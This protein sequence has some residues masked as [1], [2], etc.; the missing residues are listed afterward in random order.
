[1]KICK[2]ILVALIVL[3]TLS[4]TA[5]AY[6]GDISIT[7]NPL[8]LSTENLLEGKTVRIYA[9]VTNTSTQDLLGVT[10]FYANGKQI[11]ADQAISIFA[12]KTDD[13]F[14][15]WIPGYGNYTLKV[16]IFPW[17]AEIDDP[18]NNIKTK[19]IF[20][21]KDT[22]RD[23]TPDINDPDDDNDGLAD[24]I[25]A[26]PTDKN[27]QYD[28]DGDGKGDNSDT[29][30]DNDGVP[31]QFDDLPLDPN[32]S[33]DTDKDGIGNVKDTDDDNDGLSDTDEENLKTNPLSKDTDGDG[34]TDNKDHFPL[35]KTEWL[36]T[37]GDNIGNNLDTDDDNDGLIDIDDPFPLNKGPKIEIKNFPTTMGIFEKE[38]LDASA[39]YDEDGQITSYIWEIGGKKIEGNSINYTFFQTGEKDIKLTITDNNG[40]S[41]SKDFQIN[42]LN[43]RLYKQLA[44]L[45]IIILLA[46]AIQLK[47]IS[48]AKNRKTNRL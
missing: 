8:N 47:Y 22:D 39:S 5:L 44:I 31:D 19:E 20:V 2:K 26:F 40:E 10:R 18:S 36:D 48:N 41:R 16:Q 17:E 46:L 38:I 24:E 23:G 14:I 12:G 28:T 9:S 3:S 11:G 7:N 15:D 21:K 1:M 37:D 30:D 29:D 34:I 35:D 43:L 27:E 6:D 42:V 45:L 32:E 13:I 25:D 33:T 4:T